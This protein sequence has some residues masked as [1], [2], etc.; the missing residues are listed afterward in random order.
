MHEQSVRFRQALDS[1]SEPLPSKADE[2]V[3]STF[4]L[5]PTSTSSSDFN[6][7]YLSKHK[8]SARHVQAAL[9]ARQYLDAKSQAQN[10]KELQATLDLSNGTLEDAQAGLELLGKWKSDKAVKQAYVDAAKKRWSD[11]TVFEKQQ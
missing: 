1:L 2:V 7:T 10:E 4:T 11:A 5:I 9:S 3:K 8:D 6:T